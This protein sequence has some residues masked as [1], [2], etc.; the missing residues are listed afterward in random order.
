MSNHSTIPL[1]GCVSTPL[2]S[3]LKALGVLRLVASP[4]NNAKGVAADSSVRGWWENGQ[5]YLRSTL[6]R[7]ALLRFFLEDYTPSE[8]ISPW[9][10]GSGF[11]PDDKKTGI[12]PLMQTNVSKRF[13]P[14]HKAI[15]I[16]IEGIDRQKLLPQLNLIIG[17]KVRPARYQFVEDE[18]ILLFAYQVAKDDLA[19]EG[20]SI[21]E[22][23]LTENRATIASKKK[24]SKSPNL[25]LGIHSVANNAAHKVG[26]ISD[27][28]TDKNERNMAQ[29]QPLFNES[30]K[31]NDNSPIVTGVKIS[32]KP[33]DGKAYMA[34]EE[35]LIKVSFSEELK[36]TC[37]PKKA[38]KP[39][40]I[41]WLRSHYPASALGWLDAVLSLSRD[42]LDFPPLLGTGGND[43]RL[44]F[45]NNFMQ[46]LV[47]N[48]GLFDV[49]T[50]K[51][52]SNAEKLL[53]ASLFSDLSQGLHQSPVG[54]FFP[55]SAGGPN[56]TSSNYKGEAAVNPWDFIFMLEGTIMFAGAATRRHQSVRISG[57]SFPFTVQ[58][59]GAG[60][61][62]ASG[63]DEET[64]RAE[65][66][67]PLWNKPSGY[68][69]LK[70]LLREGRAVLNG[71]IARDGLD[72]ARAAT[73]LG[74]SRGMS[75]FERYGFV[76]RAGKAF[77]AVPIGALKVSSQVSDGAR[78]IKDLDVDSWL[79]RIRRMCK[80]KD[81][82]IH[83]R[84]ILKR[85]EDA[86][87]AITKN[88]HPSLVQNVITT[89]GELTLWLART[90]NKE[91]PPPPPRLSSEWVQ[92]ADDETPE[93]RIAC[94]L[95]SIGLQHGEDCVS[96]TKSG[97]E[98][99]VKIPMATHFV[100]VNPKSIR[101]RSRIWDE[102]QTNKALRIWGT[103]DLSS[104]LIAVLERR[105]IEQAT[106][107][108]RDKPLFAA[109]HVHLPDISAFLEPGFNHDRCGQLLTGLIWAEAHHTS[110]IRSRAEWS[111][112]PFP[113][114]ALKPI[115][116]PDKILEKYGVTQLNSQIP[117]PP[118]LVARLRNGKVDDAVHIALTRMRAS[119]VASPFSAKEASRGISRFGVGVNGRLLA[120]S[121]VI[122]LYKED[123]RHVMKQAYYIEEENHEKG[124]K[125]ANN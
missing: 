65:F 92:K 19:M 111:E 49:S 18:K 48:K 36:V 104:N 10:G 56:S 61:E 112:P 78:L 74:I 63:N 73:S 35:I 29:K 86:L 30:V 79:E 25:S 17:S 124:V 80:K 116:T 67:A 9:N 100:S 108:F 50:G 85:L 23:A 57:G 52:S 101:Y 43:G 40:F 21:D 75:E 66:W 76:E 7:E 107:G 89:L 13:F 12:E 113:Y 24:S 102:D 70:S 125:N 51:S 32:S 47:S 8:I 88:V 120:A 82:P 106:R 117:I 110:H 27:I 22:N 14:L 33:S 11:Y 16:A 99:D 53:K 93:Y 103:G 54:Q 83:A 44:D 15:Q 60:Y 42:R 4:L 1:D 94:A 96:S 115:F 105:L 69:E 114:A 28:P 62:G 122:P 3:Y 81:T 95:A 71:K 84:E 45:T 118:G 41:A 55:G 46:H 121:L 37:R 59:V 20:I 119:G 5:F 64:S 58:A 26:K 31:S 87:F 90:R 34:G 91:K 68:T 123:L 97:K 98:F 2:L 77:L 109:T 39:R 72:F 6:N 38:D